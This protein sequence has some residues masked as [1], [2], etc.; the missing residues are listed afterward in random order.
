MP[1]LFEKDKLHLAGP[2]YV[3]WAGL[4]RPALKQ[5]G[6]EVGEPAPG[7]DRIEVPKEGT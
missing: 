3:K 7:S 2:G 1:G 4:I 5:L 6:I